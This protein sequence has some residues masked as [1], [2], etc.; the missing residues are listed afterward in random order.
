M[1]RLSTCRNRAW[2]LSGFASCRAGLARQS[3][4]APGHRCHNTVLY[5]VAYKLASAA[6]WRSSDTLRCWC[7]Q[8]QWRWL[9][10][11]AR[12][13]RP[14]LPATL[15]VLHTFLRK[16]RPTRLLAAPQHAAGCHAPGPLSTTSAHSFACP[17]RRSQRTTS[18]GGSAIA[19]RSVLGARWTD[20][21]VQAFYDA[22]SVHA[23][24]PD[25]AAVA[26]AVGS[27]GAEQCQVLHQ[28]YQSFLTAVPPSDAMRQ[29]SRGTPPAGSEQV[30]AATY[31]SFSRESLLCLL[32]SH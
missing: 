10:W 6:L 20:T 19:G 27:R 18:A 5:Y 24:E 25:F 1:H 16:P 3:A 8:A 14:Q 22:P 11:Q 12:P 17:C 28:Q 21:E 7:R 30:L 29:V 13:A 31:R 32:A 9:C 26:E 2:Q 15:P 4:I 23:V